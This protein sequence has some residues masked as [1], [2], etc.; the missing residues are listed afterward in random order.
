[1]AILASEF[2]MKELKLLR[3]F[4]GIVVTK[5]AKGLFLSQSTYASDIIARAG[6]TS[7]KPSATLIDTKQKLST[8]VGT[9]YDDPTL[10]QSFCGALQ[11]LTFTR[12]D[13]SYVV[14]HV[15]F[16]MHS[17]CTEHMLP[18]KHI[19]RYVQGTL[20]FGLHLYH[21]PIEKLVSYTDANWGG[22]SDTLQSILDYCVFL[23]DNLISWFS[24][25]QPTL[26][27]SSVEYEYRGV[28]NEASK[29]CW[30]RNLLLEL[31]FPISYATL[32]HCDNVSSIYLSDNPIQHQCTKHIEMDI[33]FVR[34]VTR[35][36]AHVLHVLSR[37]QIT[38]IFT[39]GL[40]KVLFDDF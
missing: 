11:Y 15:C 9:P 32:V 7:C 20:Q 24:K 34:E 16:H 2:A 17:L 33:H 28:A 29:S 21:S 30:L 26:S 10:Y 38:Y 23:G 25:R 6:T 14:Q 31:H 13:I 39:K 1:M 35:R 36:Q 4:L 8:C 19:L 5:H 18:L 27:R 12:T 40:P 3:Y 22:C 37:H